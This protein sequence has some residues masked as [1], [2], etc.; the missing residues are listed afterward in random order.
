[1]MKSEFSVEQLLGLTESHLTTIETGHLLHVEVI[2][3]WQRLQQAALHDGINLQIASSFRSFERQLAIWN[4]KASGQRQLN[5]RLNQPLD[6]SALTSNQ[7]LDAILTWSALP[8]ASRHH[9]G[10]DLDLYDPDM[11]GALSLQLEPWEYQTGGPMAPLG[12]WLSDNLTQY[13]FYLPYHTDRGGVAIEP[14]HISHVKLSQQ[15]SSRLNVSML[16]D[17]LINTDICLSA[18]IQAKLAN[19]FIQYI[20]N[21]DSC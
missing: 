16:A 9:W 14:W 3:D 1:M 2:T 18:Q 8:G 20:S 11:L 19:I 15:A 17:A 13:G 5:D 7:L 21:V 4:A 12:Q 6:F 10:C